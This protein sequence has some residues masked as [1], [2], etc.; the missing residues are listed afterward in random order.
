ML[1]TQVGA[2]IANAAANDQQFDYYLADRLSAYSD[3]T[4]SQT[5]QY[6]ANGNRT[7]Q[8]QNGNTYLSTI[9][10]TSNRL[11]IDARPSG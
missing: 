5:Y 3:N 8:N 10:A 1:P 2:S 11:L 7:S 6:D 9:A 4:T